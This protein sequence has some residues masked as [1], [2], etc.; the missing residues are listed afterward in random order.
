MDNIKCGTEGGNN[1]TDKV[2][3]LSESESYGNKAVSH[4]FVSSS[5]IFDEARQSESST[6]A[7]AMGVLSSNGRCWWYLR[8]PGMSSSYAAFVHRSGGIISN[9]DHIC[10][11]IG[12]VTNGVRPALNLDLSSYF[13]DY[14]GTVCSD[15]ATKEISKADKN[16]SNENSFNLTL[17]KAKVLSDMKVGSSEEW[18]GVV[19][20][21]RIC[22]LLV[23]ALEDRHANLTMGAWKAIQNVFSSIDNPSNMVNISL[24]EHDMYEALIFSIL[25]NTS[26]NVYLDMSKDIESKTSELI[27]E[28][29]ECAEIKEI[30]ESTSQLKWNTFSQETKE[31][32]LELIKDRYSGTKIGKVG[33]FKDIVG[34]IMNGVN[35]VEEAVNYIVSYVSMSQM[36][37]AVKQVVKELYEQCPSS[38]KSLKHALKECYQTI[39]AT[40][41]DFVNKMINGT[42]KIVGKSAV[43]FWF[44]VY[45][46]D[47]KDKLIAANP[48]LLFLVLSAGLTT[49]TSNILFNTDETVEK[50]FN[51]VAMDTFIPIA[52]RTY[53]ALENRYKNAKTTENAEIYLSAADVIYRCIDTDCSYGANY[54]ATLDESAIG[55]LNKFFGETT[56]ANTEKSIKSVQESRKES[57]GATLTGW[58]FCLEED[59]YA[60]ELP[61]YEEI[62]TSKVNDFIKSYQIA[63]PVDIYVYDRNNKLVATVINN[64][65]KTYS[66]EVTVVVERDMKTL[67]FTDKS[68]AY[69]IQYK[70]TGRGEMD[71]VVNE[72]KDKDIVR[73]VNFNKL[74]LEKGKTYNSDYTNNILENEGYTVEMSGQKIKPNYDS[75]KAEEKYKVSIENGILIRNGVA[76][77]TTEAAEKEKLEIMAY[78]PKGY[79]FARWSVS[80]GKAIIEDTEKENTYIYVGS[81]NCSVR[82]EVVKVNGSQNGLKDDMKI[83][84]IKLS[85]ISKK[86]AAGKKIKVT[87][88]INPSTASNKTLIWQSSNKKV[89]TV[90]NSGVVTMKKNSGGKSVIITA[91]AQDGSGVKAKYKITS[92]KGAVKKISISGEK[93][94][95]AT[96]TLK[97]KANVKATKPA[98]KSR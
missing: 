95:W 20:D 59:G 91:I 8:S 42:I 92:M 53:D 52:K 87:A 56:I 50:Y 68:K 16:Q 73:T 35:D 78:V 55:K 12:N 97:L 85:G 24:E 82:A 69:N 13:Y 86:I 22:E 1:T 23:D 31:K 72:Y 49:Y 36:S 90:N 84:G 88:T 34:K 40:N 11:L 6:Y 18:R 33:D 71:I 15:G 43:S 10:G 60:S 62:I 39:T 89:A 41:V 46:S 54:V 94:V 30:L 3:L 81:T 57:Y 83:S 47:V 80:N 38:N 25:S 5:N 58:I 67:Y 76:D 7:K 48:N 75:V 65:P 21:K 45:W 27:S 26:S 74:S 2:F 29:D 77:C 79:K 70:G 19:N 66:D 4:G 96:K 17:Y 28:I 61:K 37:D 32:V 98:K 51:M 14:A 44:S 9:V 64:L 63:C 93:S